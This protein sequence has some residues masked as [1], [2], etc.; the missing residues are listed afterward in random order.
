M[1]NETKLLEIAKQLIELNPTMAIS[2]SLGLRLQLS[3]YRLRR[4]CKDLD[5]YLPYGEMLVKPDNWKIDASRDEDR[6]H[7]DA[8]TY[9]TDCFK[10]DGISIDVFTPIEPEF[11]LYCTTIDEVPVVYFSDILKMKIEHSFGKAWTKH[12][13]KDDIIFLL[14]QIQ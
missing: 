4:D 1:S 8:D 9:S 7:Y 2:G 13:H 3:K 12:K 10:I 11:N 14:S 5:M 6:T